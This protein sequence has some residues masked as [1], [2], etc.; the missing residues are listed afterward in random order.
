M[1]VR[2]EN[3]T[4]VSETGSAMVC[5]YWDQWRG[6]RLLHIRHC[7][8]D[9]KDGQLKPTAKGIAIPQGVVPAILAALKA[10]TERSAD[11][12]TADGR[13]L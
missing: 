13:A 12:E 10:A 8:R 4:L 3:M 6:S 1:A 2:E 9:K 7:Y 11:M 5:V